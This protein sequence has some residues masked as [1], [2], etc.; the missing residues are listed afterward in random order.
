MTVKITLECDIDTDDVR[1]AL[2][3]LTMVMEPIY[4]RLVANKIKVS[5][6]IAERVE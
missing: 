2:Q 5:V 4:E 6:K 3:C 1:L